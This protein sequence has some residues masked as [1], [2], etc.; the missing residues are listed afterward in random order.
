MNGATFLLPALPAAIEHRTVIVSIIGECPQDA[1]CR[2]TPVTIID[3]NRFVIVNT[4][5]AHDSGKGFWPNQHTLYTV[6]S[7]RQRG[8]VYLHSACNVTFGKGI[9]GT[10]IDNS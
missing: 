10:N 6:G 5:L 9:G 7:C 8:Q 2:I 3:D 1:C 4:Y